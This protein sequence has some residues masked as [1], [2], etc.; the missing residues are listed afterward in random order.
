MKINCSPHWRHTQGFK[1]YFDKIKI[2]Y[3][4]IQMREIA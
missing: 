2:N 4:F 1:D 3:H